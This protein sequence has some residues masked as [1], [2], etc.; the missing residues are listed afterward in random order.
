[1]VDLVP[2]FSADLDLTACDREPI[3]IP[4]SIQPH[5]A[6]LVVDPDSFE[7]LQASAN[8]EALLGARTP[9]G[10]PLAEAV[11]RLPPDLLEALR[12]WTADDEAALLTEVELEGRAF[13]ASAHRST[14][15]VLL[16]FETAPPGAPLLAPFSRLRSFAEAL[17]AAR[18]HERLCDLTAR[19]VRELNGFDRVLV[20]RFDPDW[21][22]HVVGEARNEVLPSYRHLR[23]PAGD[24]PVQARE[25]YRLNRLRIIPDIDYTPVPIRPVES[26]RARGALDL[27]LAGLRSVSPVHLEYMRNMGA[28]AS[29]SVSIIVDGRLWGLIACHNRD[30]KLVPLPVREACEFI[31]Q[32]F[33]MQV[34]SRGHAEEAAHTAALAAV[35]ARLLQQMTS[36]EVFQAGLVE[37]PETLL[38]LTGAKGAAVIVGGEIHVVGAA[39]SGAVI[40]RIMGLLDAQGRP[41]CFATES[42]AEHLPA[43]GDSTEAAGVLAISLSELHSAYL[44][45]FR[46]EVVRTVEWAGDPRKDAPAM[47]RIQPRKSF[48]TWKEQVRERAEPWR[49]PEIAAA[50]ELRGAVVGIVMRRAEEL[51]QLTEELKRSNK[52]LEAFSY[53]V[54][55]D[56]RAPFRHIVGYSE[57]LREQNLGEGKARHYV[58]SISESAVA[59]GRLVDDLLNFSHLGRT[60]LAPTRVD[61]NKLVGE[62][63]R[64]AEVDAGSRVIEWRIEPLPE[65]WGDAAMLRQVMVNLVGN[66]AKY[67]RPRE[68]AEI[69][70][71]G[72]DEG[73]ETVY[74]VR[75]NG[76]GFDAK[77]TSKMF[78][79]F[80][81]LHRAEDFEGT[82]IG[83]ALVRRIIDR[84]KGRVWAEGEIDRGAAFWFA[85]PRG[86][87]GRRGEVTNG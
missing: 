47:D 5:G 41:E 3:R 85:L 80:Q 13:Y 24:I 65:A 28:G 38:A 71:S 61:M 64:S 69:T 20:Y 57:L 70:I 25:L 78:G 62:A 7:V 26:P 39:P 84:H 8:A 18:S 34:A 87:G 29:M 75:D 74:C 15:G 82:G 77:Y 51:A 49:G 45:W 1:M 16:E 79:V 66:A 43:L 30:P 33:A 46:P 21:N 9:V 83:L 48:E 86:P 35:N 2:A 6:L 10:R 4:G 27:S 81:R 68:R 31:A 63:R 67:T 42:I 73:R 60:N 37:P 17:Q 72:E 76:V 55:H 50:R 19:Q 36:A 22:G 54:S 23:F 58:D 14:G 40:R 56:L 11:P 52:E 12:G 59:A 32:M 53:S 44:M